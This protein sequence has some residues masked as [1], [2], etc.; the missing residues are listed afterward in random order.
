M[1]HPNAIVMADAIKTGAWIGV[2]KSITPELVIKVLT[3][4]DC[5]SC[6]L[7]KRNRL[8]RQLG[9][10]INNNIPGSFISVD[11]KGPITPAA[12]GGYTGWYLFYCEATGWIKLFLVK[13]KM[14]FLKCLIEIKEYLFKNGHILRHLRFDAGSVENANDVTSYLDN[15]KT[16]IE[17]FQH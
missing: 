2:P 7:A 13:S 10:G 11:Y 1:G 16:S 17:H 3:H 5:L 12:Y 15:Q 6:A 9:S 14:K 4:I 8:P